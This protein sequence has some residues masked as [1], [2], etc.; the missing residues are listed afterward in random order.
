MQK[1]FDAQRYTMN[2]VSFNNQFREP[3]ASS[4]TAEVLLEAALSP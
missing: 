2:W 1:F 3:K 4:R